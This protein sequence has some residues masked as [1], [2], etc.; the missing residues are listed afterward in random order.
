MHNLEIRE[1][2]TAS[3]V[4]AREDAW[5]LLGK[6][7]RDRDGLTV[8][9]VLRDLDTGEVIGMPLYADMIVNGEPISVQ[10]P[11]YK[12]TFRVRKGGEVMPLGVVGKDYQI[13]QESEAF[14]FLDN[15][16]DSGEALIS[17][18]GLLAEG[19]RAFCC[20]RLPK[21]V[22]V[23]GE[24]ATDLFMFVHM[25]HDGSTPLTIAVTPIRVVCQN[26]V[27][28][29][30]RHARR[31]WRVRHTKNARLRMAEARRA[32]ELTYQYAGE[33]EKLANALL[34]KPMS[35]GQ[36][37]KLASRL[38]APEDKDSK[39]AQTI[40]DTKMAQLME[41]WSADTQDGIRG[42]AWGAW[43]AIVEWVDWFMP[44]R[45][46]ED[47]NARRFERSV[48]GEVDELKNRALGAV[49]ELVGV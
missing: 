46:A 32:L 18:A 36:Y 41:L 40:F 21:G 12:G 17:S 38:F 15:L 39:R 2:G 33:W 14:A 35:K 3:Y 6:T 45:G 30:L 43:N 49:R 31:T 28:M 48:M 13:I 7:Y 11:R 10:Q 27:T 47:V 34:G 37:S 44:A 24:D 22:L 26:T 20:M 5:H 42:T 1:N 25:S 19:R 4:G 23:G 8:E 29:G 16:V 9:E